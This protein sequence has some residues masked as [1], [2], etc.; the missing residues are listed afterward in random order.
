M[1]DV[2]GN[3]IE[4]RGLH[5]GMLPAAALLAAALTAL[6]IVV[7]GATVVTLSLGLLSLSFALIVLCGSVEVAVLDGGVRVRHFPGLSR[8]VRFH[9][10]VGTRICLDDSAWMIFG[11][12]NPRH[13]AFSKELSELGQNQ[14]VGN[15]AVV[16]DLASGT[17]YWIGTWRPVQLK[18]AI[19]AARQ[20]VP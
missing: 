14:A 10:I 19:D 11:G 17:E 3:F 7:I 2:V 16:L 20:R 12:W 1:G 9:E 15:R 4:R 13:S 18:D 6:A 5:R 8:T